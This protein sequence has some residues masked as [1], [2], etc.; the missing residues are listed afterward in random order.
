MHRPRATD[1]KA[2]TSGWNIRAARFARSDHDVTPSRRAV[3]A[4]RNGI[5]LE[6]GTGGDLDVRTYYKAY[7]TQDVMGLLF[8]IMQ[9]QVSEWVRQ[10][11]E[12]FGGNMRFDAIVAKR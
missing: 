2:L 7:P 9:G 4:K 3:V 5:I 8:G 10:L 6:N 11:V 12:M 1:R